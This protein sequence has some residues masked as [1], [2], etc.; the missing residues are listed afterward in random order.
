[1]TLEGILSARLISSRDDQFHDSQPQFQSECAAKNTRARGLAGFLCLAC[2]PAS[3]RWLTN[4]TSGL[5]RNGDGTPNLAAP[6]R[7][8]A[9]K[10][11]GGTI[12]CFLHSCK[13]LK[14]SVLLPCFSAPTA[15]TL[16]PVSPYLITVLGPPDDDAAICFV[17]AFYRRFFESD[18][19][20][21]A[22]EAGLNQLETTS[23]ASSIKPVLTET[24]AG[25]RRRGSFGQADLG[26]IPQFPREGR[27]PRRS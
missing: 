7:R 9:G 8:P 27:A 10:P 24:W 13:G 16:H 2:A 3:A 23:L 19:V 18:S 20:E 15:T 11:A 25:K 17:N 22:F 14:A 12:R 26:D 4:A 21:Q 1:M 5:P 6:V